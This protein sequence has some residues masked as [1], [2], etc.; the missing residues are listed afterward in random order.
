MEETTASME[1][2]KK[3]A[4]TFISNER[5]DYQ[6]FIALSDMHLVRK[7]VPATYQLLQETLLKLDDDLWLE[8]DTST[9]RLAEQ[10]GT[11]F[12]FDEYTKGFV[13]GVAA[14]WE[15]IRDTVL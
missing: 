3:D 13:A 4:R 2:G 14:V 5:I 15:K 12:N 10:H 6:P 7:T 1:L 8:I 11:A 9:S